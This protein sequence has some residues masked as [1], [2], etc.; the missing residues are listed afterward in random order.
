[1]NK[2]VIVEIPPAQMPG[3]V[4]VLHDV[5]FGIIKWRILGL[6]GKLSPLIFGPDPLFSQDTVVQ[7]RT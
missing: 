5:T 7:Q 4:S 2:N 6:P 1:M 3:A